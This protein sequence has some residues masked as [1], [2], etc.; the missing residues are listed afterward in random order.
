MTPEEEE[1]I[2]AYTSSA[3][4]KNNKYLAQGLTYYEEEEEEPE[5]EEPE[6]VTPETPPAEEGQDQET[7]GDPA[8]TPED[9]TQQ[10]QQVPTVTLTEALGLAPVTAS[11][12]GYQVT[13]SYVEGSYFALQAE[14]GNQYV[15]LTIN[16]SNST[17]QSVECNNIVRNLRCTLT[18]NGTQQAE[19]EPTILLND[20]ATYLNTLEPG[21]VQDTI[22]IFEVPGDV[23]G[24][25]QSLAMELEVDGT[26]YHVDLQ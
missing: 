22:L 20:L 11:Y 24:N 9:N 17:E 5:T 10:E 16:L 6:A 3:V 15:V 13:D 25:I 23:A 19:A 2:V 4:A 12:R 18:V 21:A 1:L 8:Q 7:T 14:A 26:A